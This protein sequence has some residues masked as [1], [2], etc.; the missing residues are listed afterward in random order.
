MFALQE[1]KTEDS[2]FCAGA[3]QQALHRTRRTSA[4]LVNLPRTWSDAEFRLFD[5][6]VTVERV[7]CVRGAPQIGQSTKRKRKGPEFQPRWSSKTRDLEFRRGLGRRL[8]HTEGGV[9]MRWPLSGKP[10]ASS[11]RLA[12]RHPLQNLPVCLWEATGLERTERCKEG[13]RAPMVRRQD[14]GEELSPR[15]AGASQASTSCKRYSRV[16]P[17]KS[18]RAQRRTLSVSDLWSE[19]CFWRRTFGLEHW[20]GDRC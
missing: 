3:V 4:V 2:R 12:V 20:A 1:G 10:A 6:S 18:C 14:R 7:V 17:P 11:L 5:A 9:E 16:D 15:F 13:S 19:A 8:R